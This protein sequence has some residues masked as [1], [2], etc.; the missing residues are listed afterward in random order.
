MGL[1]TR[2]VVRVER[3]QKDIRMTIRKGN[4]S[5]N[6][7]TGS[8]LQEGLGSTISNRMTG[9][10][11]IRSIGSVHSVFVTYFEADLE[12]EFVMFWGWSLGPVVLV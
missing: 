9:R 2:A 5:T 8:L 7:S 6:R 4:R 3:I 11:T 1:G 10:T 12:P